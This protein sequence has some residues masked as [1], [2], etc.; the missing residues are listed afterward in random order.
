MRH[1]LQRAVGVLLLSGGVLSAAGAACAAGVFGDPAVT[2]HAPKRV[3]H[4]EN[5]K[6]ALRF[7]P[8]KGEIFG[9]ETI[10]LTPRVAALRRF[11]LDSAELAIERVTLDGVA[12]HTTALAFTTQPSRLWITLPRASP[13]GAAL[14][15]A[16]RYHG[17]PRAGLYF[18]NPDAHYPNRPREIWSQGEPRFNHFWFP[19]WDYPND[20]S[21]SETVTTVPA[22]LRVVSNGRLIEVTRHGG[23]VTYDWLESVPHS[24][25]LTSI[26]IGPWR[27]V[28][29]RYGALPVDEYV[30]ESISAARARRSFHLTP[31]MIGFFDRALAVPYPYEKYAQVAVA[32]DP[33][34][35][36]ENVSATTISDAVLGSARADADYS[37][38]GVVS[39]ELGQHWFG[40]LVQGRDWADIW[41]NEGFATYLQALYTQDHDGNGAFRLE[42]RRDQRVARTE[43]RDAYLRPIVD[44]HYRYPLQMF[45]GITHQKGAV[46]LDM[47]RNLLDGSAAASAP[48]SQKELFFRALKAY[49]TT[50]RTH[51]VTTAQLIATL[52]RVTGRKLGRFFDE[53]VYGAG[54]PDYR[55]TARYEPQSRREKITVTQRQ[56]GPG[57]SW[58]F[59]MPVTL[60]L[61]GAD[62]QSRTVRIRDRERSQTFHVA[63]RFRPRWLDFDPDD[64]IEKSLRFPQ[65]MTALIAK[66]EH[67][68][69]PMSRISAVRQLAAPGARAPQSV[70]AA[71]I[72]VLRTDP[73]YGVRQQA[74]AS[75]GRLHSPC[76]AR[77]LLAALHQPDRR[78]RK[79][80]IAALAGYHDRSVYDALL[81]A[82]HDDASEA[83]QSAAARALGQDSRLGAFSALQSEASQ[84][85]G[86]HIMKGV[87]AG[88]AATRDRRAVALLLADARPGVNEPLRLAALQTLEQTA[89]FTP[90]RDRGML[91]AD[92]RSALND[93]VLLI[94]LEGETLCGT[95]GLKR[96][97]GV[98]RRRVRSEPTAFQRDSA[99]QAFLQLEKHSASTGASSRNPSR[100]LSARASA[101]ASTL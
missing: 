83:V 12:G 72:Q 95:Y 59:V 86:I 67:D 4:V 74:A 33:F 65:P 57:V 15:I 62:G 54:H 2:Q 93:P 96:F 97:R 100:R 81:E 52:E 50:Y 34:G 101:S 36:M 78:V 45:D 24:S 51:A 63:V 32:D 22:G 87:L 1:S 31:D 11:Y 70:S 26:A 90:H 89:A 46:V 69:A 38:Q 88:L 91:I 94:R 56:H 19:C 28:R 49:L 27:T 71:L 9:E 60:A 25:Y 5:Y 76:A 6:L 3:Y 8:A 82:L 80:A 77:A 85:V 66:S 58:V 99:R 48:A 79:A 40:D 53:W 37:S 41:L 55:V 7:D 23:L 10:T 21:T 35:G 39:H 30:P 17:F 68:P 14:R 18:V 16:I 73:F 98:L 61:Y 13:R 43:D 44:D 42:M 47:L 29:G 92:V 20:M 84:H 64:I 75:L